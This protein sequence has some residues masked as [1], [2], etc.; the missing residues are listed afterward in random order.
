MG[1]IGMLPR[2][3]AASMDAGRAL[4]MPRANTTAP[5]HRQALNEESP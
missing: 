4:S 1:E 3:T 2:N 5:T